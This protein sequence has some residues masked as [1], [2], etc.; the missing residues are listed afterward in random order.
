ME[1]ADPCFGTV[2]LLRI[3]WW[4]Q[5]RSTLPLCAAGIESMPH[6]KRRFTYCRQIRRT[7][8][9]SAKYQILRRAGASFRTRSD[10]EQVAIATVGQAYRFTTSLST[11]EW[12]EFQSLHGNAKA[13]LKAAAQNAKAHSYE[14]SAGAFG[15]AKPLDG[16]VGVHSI[17]RSA[18]PLCF[19][20]TIPILFR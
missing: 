3:A 8:G 14:R 4:L 16:Y 13:A 12:M 6:E 18:T 9:V 19:S 10:G 17:V 2:D 5:V 11:V 1:H 15:R 20:K 7:F